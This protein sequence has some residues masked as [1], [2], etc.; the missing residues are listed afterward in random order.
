[1]ASA[2]RIRRTAPRFDPTHLFNIGSTS[3]SVAAWGAIRLVDEGRLSLDEPV[4]ARLKRW[5]LPV[6]P[7][8]VAEVTLRRL[9][10]HT[11]G[12]SLDGYHDWGTGEPR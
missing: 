2:W 5:H 12:L 8:Q 7:Y 3:K 11:A 4:N 9:L 6:S 1:M 10:S